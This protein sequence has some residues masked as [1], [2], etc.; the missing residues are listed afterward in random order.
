MVFNKTQT[1]SNFQR[2]GPV[3][4]T[5][6]TADNWAGMANN[7]YNMPH[8]YILC[9]V[10]Q[11][12]ATFAAI[13]I[14]IHH[15]FITNEQCLHS[16]KLV[17]AILTLGDCA[18]ENINHTHLEYS[19]MYCCKYT[20]ASRMDMILLLEFHSDPPLVTIVCDCLSTNGFYTLSIVQCHCFFLSEFWLEDDVR[21]LPDREE[22]RG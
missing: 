6:A 20:R 12:Q 19:C 17:S 13:T 9:I 1:I 4:S 18:C 3:D 21:S 7:S 11:Q 15:L 22:L 16:C 14:I 8:M 2:T 10:S 5:G